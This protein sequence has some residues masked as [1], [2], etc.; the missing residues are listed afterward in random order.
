M[1]SR[2]G[3]ESHG[4]PGTY[5]LNRGGKLVNNFW[6]TFDQVLLRPALLPFYRADGIR[7]LD[8]IGEAPL[9]RDGVIDKR[10]SD[11]PPVVLWL[12]TEREL[13]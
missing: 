8:R 12:N 7:V 3:D 6:E 1:W 4:P 10:F 11:H 5:Y 9:L 13:A 2:L